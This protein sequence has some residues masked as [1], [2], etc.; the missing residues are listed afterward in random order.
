VSKK[1]GFKPQKL[2]K[3]EASVTNRNVVVFIFFLL[4][5]FLFWYLNSMG[6][7]QEVDIK[8]PVKYINLPK[9]K[10]LAE[11]LPARLTF[12]LKG[13]G[14]SIL[15]LK[16]SGNRAPAVIDFSK[17][18]YKKVTD[19]KSADYYLVT[20]GLIQ[21]ISAQLKSECTITSVKPDTLFLSFT[22]PAR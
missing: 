1:D 19:S 7:D 20:S 5:S 18:S 12:Y 2:A 3:K 16:Y 22:Q 14:Y 9:N 21:D 10:V 15:R 11:E 6:K 17:T 8:Y 13:P 4:L